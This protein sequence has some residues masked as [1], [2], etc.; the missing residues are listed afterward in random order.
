M[1]DRP[2]SSGTRIRLFWGTA[3]LVVIAIAAIIAVVLLTG[4]KDFVVEGR[5]SGN[6]RRGVETGF[7]RGKFYSIPRR[8]RPYRTTTRRHF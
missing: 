5:L 1:N 7:S 3:V 4:E 2:V 8:R 6:R